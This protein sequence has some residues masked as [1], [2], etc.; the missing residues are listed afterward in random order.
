MFNGR[1]ETRGAPVGGNTN[2]ELKRR[3]KKTRTVYVYH[4]LYSFEKS[5]SKVR[6]NFIVRIGERS[7]EIDLMVRC[8]KKRITEEQKIVVL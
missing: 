2:T 7:E 6:R 5:C 3:K 8:N 1:R 4:K